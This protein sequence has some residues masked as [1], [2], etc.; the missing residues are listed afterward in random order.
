MKVNYEYNVHLTR[1]DV[2]AMLAAKLA[3]VEGFPEG[4]QVDPATIDAQCSGGYDAYGHR[5]SGG[6][7]V[8]FKTTNQTA[9]AKAAKA[10]AAKAKRAKAK[11]KKAARKA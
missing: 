10:K 8:T 7:E 11:A 1:E 3:E 4:Q 9:A 6:W 5:R 2:A